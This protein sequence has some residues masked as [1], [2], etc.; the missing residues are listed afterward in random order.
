VTTEA[1]KC[2]SLGD[3]EKKINPSP[4]DQGEG[5]GSGFELNSST[6][7]LRWIDAEDAASRDVAGEERDHRGREM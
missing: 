6:E 3:S 5:Q 4:W 1:E 7:R 2:E